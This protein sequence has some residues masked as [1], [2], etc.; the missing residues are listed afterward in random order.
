MLYRRVVQY[1][2]FNCKVQLRGYSGDGNSRHA[3]WGAA[4]E[5]HNADGPGGE[6][7]RPGAGESTDRNPRAGSDHRGRPAPGPG[8]TGGRQ[9]GSGQDAARAELPGRRRPQVRRARRADDL[10]G[11][12]GQGRPERAL[13]RIRSRR[14]QRRMACSRCSRSGWIRPRSSRRESSTSNRSS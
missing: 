3:D 12:G 5:H 2:R 14:A 13:A 1:P 10:R 7:D 6:H 8:D 11:V 4:G 9:R